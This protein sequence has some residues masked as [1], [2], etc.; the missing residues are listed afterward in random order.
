MKR[1][2]PGILFADFVQGRGKVRRH[3]G[4]GGQRDYRRGWVVWLGTMLAMGLILVRAFDLQILQGERLRVLADENRI[5]QIRL[6]A[7][8]GKI[9]DRNGVEVVRNEAAAQVVGYLGEVKED[10]VGLVKASG[11]KYEVG[12]WIGRA[13]VEAQ[14]EDILRGVDGGKLVEVDNEG[15][16]V[17]EL[18]QKEPVAGRDVQLAIDGGLQETAYDAVRGKKAGVIVAN[19]QNGEILALVSSPSFDPGLVENYLSRKDLP[20]FNRAIGGVYPPGSTFKMITTMAG[21]ETGKVKPS[22]TFVDTG[23]IG[24]GSFRYTNWLF[25]KRGGTEGRIGF[26]RAITRS[27]DTF[28]YKVGE[29]A[30]P[31]A[32]VEWAKKV[33]LGQITG[34][35]LPG[36]VPGWVPDPSTSSG[37]WYLGNTYHL[38]IGQEDLL[39]TPLQINLMTNILA[40][41]GKKCRPHLNKMFN[42]QC[43]MI[44]ISNETLEIIKNGMIGACSEGGTSFVMFDWNADVKL[45]KIACKTGTAEYVAESGKVKTHG[46]LTAYAPA[47]NPV[48]SATV[49]IEGGGEGSNVAAPV[50]RK[51]F[52]KYFNVEDK[53][54]Y[55][56]IRGE[57]E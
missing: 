29:L 34:I 31:E 11:G 10:E 43:S 12:S 33:G 53:Y 42:V 14:Y 27:T 50:V 35:D 1:F 38:A 6:A 19:P 51:I 4:A 54:P 48:I 52:A 8:R 13:G 26:A 24:V 56:A 16:I 20:M 57:G 39:A 45:P 15:K 46:W 37:P 3:G 30:G 41:N 23:M 32:M 9:R 18:G 25:T 21:L 7:P 49:V 36:E 2:R 40:S 28:F 17:R 55:G 47:D 5:K 22:F 44:N